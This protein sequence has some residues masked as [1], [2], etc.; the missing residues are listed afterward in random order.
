MDGQ[1]NLPAQEGILDF[2]DE[3]PLAADFRQ[4]HI[5]D[6]V[7]GSLDA[8]QGDG[9]TGDQFLEARS[10]PLTLVHSQFTAAC[11]ENKRATHRNPQSNRSAMNTQLSVTDN[12]LMGITG[13]TDQLT[14]RPCS[15]V[16]CCTND[17]SE[18]RVAP[19]PAP[20]SSGTS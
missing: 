14:R 2:F 10:N 12:L 8:L 11:P 4:R 9:E 20:L 7:A 18:N 13:E 5:E 6:F 1:V 19:F 16:V 15:F 17:G 3:Q